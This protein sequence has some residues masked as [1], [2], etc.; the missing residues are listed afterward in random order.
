M[1]RIAV[2]LPLVAA[3]FVSGPAFAAVGSHPTKHSKH[4][5]STVAVTQP[6]A[7][8]GKSQQSGANGSGLKKT[9]GT[10][11]TTLAHKVGAQ[12]TAKMPRHIRHHKKQAE[13]K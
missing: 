11:E 4:A 9:T 6:A 7:V 12:G 5:A 8:A 1:K 13:A 2:I 10:H 3:A